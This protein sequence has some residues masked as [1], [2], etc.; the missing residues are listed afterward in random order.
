MVVVAKDQ[1]V[2]LLLRSSEPLIRFRALV[3]LAGVDAADPRVRRA[4]EAIADGPIV[5]ALLT[6]TPHRHPYSKWIGAHWRLVSLVDLG[7]PPDLPEIRDRLDEGLD[8]IL[9]WLTGPGD[10]P[11]PLKG[12]VIRGLHRRCASQE[13]N[14]LAVAVHLGRADDPRSH[15]LVE[16]L[17]DWQWPD[18]GWN[19]DRHPEAHH[20]SANET[21][22]PLR[23]LAAFASRTTDP[24]A[25]AAAREAA[26]RTAEFFL[27]HRV[28]F[29]ERTGEPMNPRVVALHYPPYWHYDVLVGLRALVESGHIA[30]PRTAD[31][32]ELLEGRRGEDGAWAAD[33]A[34]YRR[35]GST[36]RLPEVA[37]WTGDVRGG[38]NEALTLSALLVLKAAGRLG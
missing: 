12:P 24:S 23:G 13:G 29:S 35:P 1:G 20:S 31:A 32:L 8:A 10:K 4:R 38:P 11:R 6:D 2:D 36:A 21:F 16:S 26:D 9:R 7:V 15:L 33:T 27:R 14:G 5:Q 17:L 22:A 3:D 37:D 30:D 18:G 28:A 19:C 25:A 34:W